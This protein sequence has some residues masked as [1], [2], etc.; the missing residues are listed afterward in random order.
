ML[1]YLYLG[2]LLTCF[3]LAL[4][5]R[6]QGS[7][8]TYTGAVIGFALITVYM[9]VRPGYLLRI[10]A[11]T[12]YTFNLVRCLLLGVQGYRE[13]QSFERRLDHLW[14]DLQRPNLLHHRLVIGGHA[15]TLHPCVTAFRA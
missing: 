8:W 7:K 4:G 9:T 3:L 15:R 5:N 13:H 11:G 10:R 1:K 14:D 2:L 6:P 12:D